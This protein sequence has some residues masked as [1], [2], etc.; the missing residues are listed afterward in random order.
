MV[1]TAWTLVLGHSPPS[2]IGSGS[3]FKYVYGSSQSCTKSMLS[4]LSVAQV[5]EHIG[6]SRERIRQLE[7]RGLAKLMHPSWRAV[8]RFLDA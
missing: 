4:G 1:N 6:L 7:H 3:Q 5:A 2:C 8:G